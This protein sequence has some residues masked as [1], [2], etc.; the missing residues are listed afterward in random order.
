MDFRFEP[1]L[2]HF[3]NTKHILGD[4]DIV[5]WAGAGKA[6]L[7]TDS[8]AFALKQLELSHKLH[9]SCEVH[10][11]QHRDCGG[12]GGSKQFESPQDEV[13]FHTDQITKIKSLISEKLPDVAFKV[14]G[15]F[16]DFTENG[17]VV[18]NPI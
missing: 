3:L 8:Q 4:A 14:T 13:R 5:G 6:F 16:A 1:G 10:I 2:F 12:Y 9:N 7:D 11:I 18:I 15:Y 17:D